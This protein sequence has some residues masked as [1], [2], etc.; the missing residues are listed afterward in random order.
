MARSEERGE[1]TAAQD[2][3][4]RRR[5]LWSDRV[6]ELGEKKELLYSGV[7]MHERLAAFAAL[8]ERVWASHGRTVANDG[9]DE[10]PGEVFEIDVHGQT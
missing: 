9:R 6:V 10:W 4:M 2:R 1:E 8:N 5:Q 3:A 7:S